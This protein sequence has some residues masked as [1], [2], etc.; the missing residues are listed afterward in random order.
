MNTKK[1][2]ALFQSVTDPDWTPVFWAHADQSDEKADESQPDGYV[3]VSP[4]MDVEFTALAQEGVIEKQLAQLD[5][6]ELAVREEMQ[7]RLDQIS[8]IRQRLLAL[9]FQAA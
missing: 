2:I 3:R 5:K 6:A 7:R 8:D 1:R 9:T 4:Y